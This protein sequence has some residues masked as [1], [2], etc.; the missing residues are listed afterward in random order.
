MKAK[1]PSLVM[2]EIDVSENPKIG[3]ELKLQGIPFICYYKNGK[4]IDYSKGKVKE[5]VI[6][7]IHYFIGILSIS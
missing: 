7:G 6:V 1:Y 2:A 5:W 3:R 4:R